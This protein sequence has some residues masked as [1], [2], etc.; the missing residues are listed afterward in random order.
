MITRVPLAVVRALGDWL[1]VLAAAALVAHL[2]WLGLRPALFE[3]VRLSGARESLAR[4]TADLAADEAELRELERAFADPIYQERLRWQWRLG[5]GGAAST[6]PE[7]AD[8]RTL[9]TLRGLATPVD[10]LPIDVG[11]EAAADAPAAPSPAQAAAIERG[12][13]R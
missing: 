10:A 13:I 8:E 9:R 11:A 5:A 12:R 2:S 3:H 4:E 6:D 1:P 7:S